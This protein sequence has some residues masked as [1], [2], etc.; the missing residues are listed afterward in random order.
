M[1]SS[2]SKLNILETGSVSVIRCKG[3]KFPIHFGPLDRVSLGHCT[4]EVALSTEYILFMSDLI[5]R[6]EKEKNIPRTGYE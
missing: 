5:S 3:G 6:K 2:P 4:P 1:S